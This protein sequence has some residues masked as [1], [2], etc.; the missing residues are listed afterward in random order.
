MGVAQSPGQKG[1][2][3]GPPQDD[4]WCQVGRGG[5]G[6]R[7]PFYTF[8]RGAPKGLSR[9]QKCPK[10]TQG[11]A[12]QPEP[13]P[14]SRKSHDCSVLLQ[15]S[16]CS[17]RE[18]ARGAVGAR[19]RRVERRREVNTRPQR[20]PV[21]AFREHQPPPVS[22]GCCMCGNETGGDGREGRVSKRFPKLLS[23]RLAFPDPPAHSSLG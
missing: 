1:S 3:A 17:G 7:Q 11:R 12:G 23:T 22:G 18:A 15:V 20:E 21:P 14:A 8:L 10:W 2:Q 4:I 16:S 5:K 9:T 13:Q 6:G 19:R